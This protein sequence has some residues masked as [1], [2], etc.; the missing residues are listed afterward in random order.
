MCIADKYTVRY[1][2][3]YII[4]STGVSCHTFLCRF[5][6]I[7]LNKNKSG[8][9]TAEMAQVSFIFIF[10]FFITSTHLCTMMM[11]TNLVVSL[12]G[13]N[14]CKFKNQDSRNEMFKFILN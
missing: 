14:I 2:Q 5:I 7:F 10:Y 11:M 8:H 12:K 9:K 1:C 3:L 4:E 6:F 13:K